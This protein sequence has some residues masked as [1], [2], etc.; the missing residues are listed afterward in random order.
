MNYTDY[1]TWTYITV[2]IVCISIIIGMIIN[3]SNKDRRK[4]RL[5]SQYRT[6]KENFNTLQNMF[7]MTVMTQK[8][9]PETLHD[10]NIVSAC[11]Q[12]SYI[13]DLTENPRSPISDFP[14]NHEY[15]I[16]VKKPLTP[17]IEDI[18]G[19]CIAGKDLCNEAIYKKC[20]NS[21]DTN[22]RIGNSN[23]ICTKNGLGSLTAANI[24]QRPRQPS[25]KIYL[26]SDNQPNLV[27]VGT[28][29]AP[30]GSQQWYA[31]QDTSSLRTPFTTGVFKPECCTPNTLD[32]STD[33]G[34]LC[35]K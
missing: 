9:I 27:F 3:Q 26:K 32:I 7:P 28:G 18:R 5:R 6:I 20:A 4:T 22:V 11:T 34:C 31:R 15:T 33:H 35:V 21:T 25:P 24:V 1:G 29:G 30:I 17:Y 2:Y 19:Q 14:L 16:S 10:L 23:V 12:R 8:T 13:H